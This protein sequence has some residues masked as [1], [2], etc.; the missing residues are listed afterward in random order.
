MLLTPDIKNINIFYHLF[1]Q[2]HDFT[3]I[4][5]KYRY[6]IIVPIPVLPLIVNRIIMPLPKRLSAFSPYIIWFVDVMLSVTAT[7]FAVII[8]HALLALT[9]QSYFIFPL[10]GISFVASIICTWLFHTYK[11]VISHS[12]IGEFMRLFYVAI[13]KMLFMV[14]AP[15]LVKD[16]AYGLFLTSILVL[17]GILTAWALI[18]WRIILIRCYHHL[19]RLSSKQDLNVMIYGTSEA[20]ICLAI[21]LINK[22]SNYNVNGFFTRRKELDNMRIQG[23][24]THCF[25]SNDDFITYAQKHEIN[26]MLFVTNKEL[27]ADEGLVSACLEK[28]ISIRISPL[29]EASTSN[30][31]AMQVRNIQIEDLLGRDEIQISMEKIGKEIADKTIMITGAAGSIGSEI[32]RQ[33]CKFNPKNLILVDMGETPTYEIDLEIRKKYPEQ[34]F[35]AVISDVR[36]YDRMDYQVQLYKP[37]I[38]MHAAAYKHVPLMEQFPCEAVRANILGSKNMAELA[39]KYGIERFVMVST[40]KSINPSN[41]MGASKHIAEMYVQSLGQ[42]VTEGKLS[43]KTKFVTTRFGNVLGSNGSVIPLFRRQIMSGGPITITHPDIIRYFMTIPEACRLVLEAAF[44][45]QG[46]DIFLF[47]MG[48]PVKIVDL[49]RRMIE[50]AGLRPDK[51]IEIQYIGLRPGEKL[52][53]ELL[54]NKESAIPTTHPKIFRAQTVDRDYQQV[55]AKIEELIAM[56]VTGDKLETVRLMKKIAPAYKSLNSKYAELDKESINN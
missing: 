23:I 31:A 8:M 6:G 26:C 34:N 19:V 49:A 12:G 4:C 15:L 18:I 46:N 17:D 28:G 5:T 48:E 52:Y 50:L 42:A 9:I 22:N 24:S 38:I 36:D 7:A 35:T 10:L 14:T 11:G 45:G 16:L 33:L 3:Y 39:V 32:C 47:D 51:D 27:H 30:V 44:M 2:E 29:M 1:G 13:A 55:N 21:Y 41:V 53:E 40:D 54:Y 20:A 25:Q 43:G 56:A 37:D